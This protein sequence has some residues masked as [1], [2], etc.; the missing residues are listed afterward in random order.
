MQ[1]GL[2][3]QASARARP[4]ER[5]PGQ[6]DLRF[7]SA[8]AG[9]DVCVWKNLLSNRVS[10]LMVTFAQVS[11]DNIKNASAVR[12]AVTDASSTID[13]YSRPEKSSAITNT[14][15]DLPRDG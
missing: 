15:K 1:L 11:Q 10:G 5:P 3:A 4:S 6:N 9:C 14:L 12:S 2:D 8:Q 13:R 7:L